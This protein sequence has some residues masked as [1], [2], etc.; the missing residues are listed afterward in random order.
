VR[1]AISITDGQRVCKIGHG[2]EGGGDRGPTVHV[3][4]PPS[5]CAARS[6][7]FRQGLDGLSHVPPSSSALYCPGLVCG[8]VGVLCSIAQDVYAALIS[9]STASLAWEDLLGIGITLVNVVAN[10]FS[11]NFKYLGLSKYAL[12]SFAYTGR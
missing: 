3:R 1:L 5:P 11:T 9:S 12:P 10:A 7:V 6:L 8:I 2:A 4:C